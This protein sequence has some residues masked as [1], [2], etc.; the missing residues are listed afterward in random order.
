M[1]YIAL[2]LK[3]I[4]N[5][6]ERWE[7]RS[8]TPLELPTSRVVTLIVSVTKLLKRAILTSVCLLCDGQNQWRSHRG[9]L[10]VRTPH[11][12]KCYVIFSYIYTNTIKLVLHLSY[13]FYTKLV[14]L[15]SI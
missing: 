5:F 12:G 3:K 11:C 15:Y 14:L 8:Q 4:V 10:G 1:L 7:L 2:F 13:F 6:S 9:G